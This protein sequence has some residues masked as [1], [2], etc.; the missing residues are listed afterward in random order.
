MSA[1]NDI[2]RAEMEVSPRLQ[3]AIVAHQIIQVVS[4]VVLVIIYATALKL[5]EDSFH[6]K[7]S[8]WTLLIFISAIIPTSLFIIFWIA[9]KCNYQDLRLILVHFNPVLSIMWFLVFFPFCIICPILS[10]GI[11][12]ILIA[13]ISGFLSLSSAIFAIYGIWKSAR[14]VVLSARSAKY[15]HYDVLD[16]I[17]PTRE[18]PSTYSEI[19]G[20]RLSQAN[21]IQPI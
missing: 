11:V 3:K 19:N 4:P 9:S 1:Q 8:P 20:V 5:S 16:S 12:T 10:V 15:E 21:Y 13:I 7:P 14:K 17:P 2:L 18:S 6:H